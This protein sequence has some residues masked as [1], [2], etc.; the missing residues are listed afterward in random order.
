MNRSRRRKK[1][2]LIR[3]L[4]TAATTTTVVATGGFGTL[5]H[6]D[7][8]AD[9]QQVIMETV[10]GEITQYLEPYL[11][12]EPTPIARQPTQSESD[13]P[14][15]LPIP[16]SGRDTV[17]PSD[18]FGQMQ[19][20]ELLQ[21]GVDFVNSAGTPVLAAAPGQVIYAGQDEEGLFSP[22]PEFYGLLVVLQH[23]LRDFEQPIYTFYAHLSQ[24]DVDVG[25]QIDAGEKIALVGASGQT[26]GSELHFEVRYGE[27][28]HAS[29]RNPELWLAQFDEGGQQNGALAGRILDE[30]GEP[31]AAKVVVQPLGDL[32]L[33]PIDLFTYADERLALQPPWGETFSVGNL[34]PG[35]YKISF[36]LPG[37]G[38][39]SE[40][41]EIVSGRVTEWEW[42]KP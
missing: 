16:A 24:I 9:F 8:T 10:P 23:S 6:N 18:R 30:V 1:A 31:M 26:T 28:S 13:F 39:Q 29:A 42:M 27:N 40:V 21:F 3:S 32:G 36:S 17:D 5:P 25:Q 35:E 14:L 33:A 19:N 22:Y 2:T 20:E 38:Y 11:Y 7:L 4:L 15:A 34:P 41:V 37:I 12:T